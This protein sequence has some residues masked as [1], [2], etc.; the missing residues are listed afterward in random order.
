MHE[1]VRLQREVRHPQVNIPIVIVIAGINAHRAVCDAIAV[2]GDTAQH[3]FLPKC[4]ISLI[5][6]KGIRTH[7]VGDVD[8]QPTIVVDIGKD[9]TEPAR[10]GFVNTGRFGNIREGA[11]AVIA[12]QDI[13]DAV[14]FVR[15][16]VNTDCFFVVAGD[17]CLQRVFNVVANV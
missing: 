8:V 4:A 1:A 11:V 15:A 2:V 10:G 16:A 14:I 9:D 3:A 12:I 13:G 5:H 17:V 6:E 7:V